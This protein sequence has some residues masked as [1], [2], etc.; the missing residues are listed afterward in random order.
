M[1]TRIYWSGRSY[2][3][4][5]EIVAEEIKSIGDDVKPE[6]LV[7]YAEEHED[8]E[9]YKCFTWD[10]DDAAEKWRL[11]EARNIINHLK[12]EITETDATEPIS[13]RLMLKTDNDSG[14]KETLKIVENVDEYAQML[15]RAK[16]ELYAFQTKYSTL[17]E[18]EDVFKAIEAL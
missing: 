2:K 11:H 15:E 8:S 12:I 13:F 1:N 16:R 4:K 14:Y 10:N 9:L 3:G 18:L 6:E 5:A 17:L 7:T